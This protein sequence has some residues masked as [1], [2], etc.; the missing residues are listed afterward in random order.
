MNMTSEKIK[1]AALK[2]FAQKGYEGTPLSEIAAL[3]G[4]KTPS[5]YAHFA[6]KEGLFLSIYHDLVS[7]EYKTIERVI[8]DNQFQRMEE[9][10]KAIFF[11][12]TDIHNQKDEKLFFK[13]AIFFPPKGL[14][15]RLKNDFAKDEL[16]S[17]SLLKEL[18]TNGMN[19][20]EIN[21][22][23]QVEELVNTFYCL[24]DGLLVESHY[25]AKEVFEKRRDSVW[26]FFWNGM[27]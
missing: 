10:L 5:I 6:S 8:G 9:K 20:G 1:S 23:S 25:Y 14:E 18:F 4:I 22:T 15:E 11:C 13:R 16:K 24:L 27:K 2:L 26:N 17:A 12:L 3:V 21:T 7:N 19:N